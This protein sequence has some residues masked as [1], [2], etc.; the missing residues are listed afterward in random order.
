MGNIANKMPWSH[1][2][3]L[4]RPPS[5]YAWDVDPPGNIGGASGVTDNEDRALRHVHHE[6]VDAPLGTRGIVRRVG[7]AGI[8]GR[9]YADLGTVATARRDE[10]TGAVVW[11]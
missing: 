5:L 4:D 11:Q 2:R 3:H 10:T 9:V 1:A 8:S 6:L 7:L